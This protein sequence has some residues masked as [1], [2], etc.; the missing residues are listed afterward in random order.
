MP[1]QPEFYFCPNCGKS[2]KEAPL[3]TT[4]ATQTWIYAL[5]IIM[6]IIA[7]LALHYWPGIKYLRSGDEKMK[8]IGLVAIVLMALS[9]IITYWISIVWIQGFIQSSVNGVSGLGAGI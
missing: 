8:Q 2:L 6:P 5:S 3:S 9:T 1:M 7:F 4:L